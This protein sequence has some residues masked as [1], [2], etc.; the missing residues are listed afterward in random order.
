MSLLPV[1]L[2]LLLAG[3]AMQLNAALTRPELPG[4]SLPDQL[5]PGMFLVA[6]RDFHDPYFRG[7]VVYLLQH[8]RHATLGVI[9][10]YPSTA[11]LQEWLPELEG[12]LPGALQ[13]YNGGPLNPEVMTVLVDHWGWEE[14]YDAA[15]V[16][17]VQDAVFATFDP[18]IFARLLGADAAALGRV[19]CYYGHIGWYAGQLEHEL[20][21]EYWHLLPGDIDEVLGA[22]ASL[23][24][25]RLIERLEPAE[26][27]VQP[28]IS[29]LPPAR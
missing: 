11:R 3:G 25:H 21:R 23:L 7:S 16:L 15:D 28:V 6:S 13:V 1:C 2:L 10:N 27:V 22:Q 5:A 8:D 20:A 12:T 9:V 14:D 24:W 29:A 4:D 17:H 18:A 26:P 19:R